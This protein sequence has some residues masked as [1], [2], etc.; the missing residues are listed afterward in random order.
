MLRIRSLVLTA[1]IAIPSLSAAQ[2]P[3]RVSEPMDSTKRALVQQLVIAAR[4]KEQ[5]IRTMRE[6]SQLQT[7]PVPP[8]FWDRM[9]VRATEDVDALIATTVDDY[10]SYFTSTEIRELIAFYGTPLG[11]RL[12]DVTPV[13]GARASQKGQEW[14]MRVGSEVG[15]QLMQQGSKPGGTT[16]PVKPASKP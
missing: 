6:S 9:I 11:K 13:I 5:V 12:L 8:G 15:Q 10:G 14:G 16:K 4:M 2:R 1:L 3:E 7:L